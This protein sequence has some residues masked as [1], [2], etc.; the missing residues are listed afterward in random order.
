MVLDLSIPD[1]CTLTYFE[2]CRKFYKNGNTYK[3]FKNIFND[4]QIEGKDEILTAEHEIRTENKKTN[5]K[6]TKHLFTFISRINTTSESFKTRNTYICKH[7][8]C[9]E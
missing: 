3:L 4:V 9:Y 6:Q 1:L 2:L 7:L 5:K 8:N